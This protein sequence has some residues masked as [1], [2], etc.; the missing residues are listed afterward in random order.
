MKIDSMMKEHQRYLT[1]SSGRII[2]QYFIFMCGFLVHQAMVHHQAIV[3]HQV[4]VHYVLIHCHTI[5]H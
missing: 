3:H 5:N 1:L 2:F 4:M